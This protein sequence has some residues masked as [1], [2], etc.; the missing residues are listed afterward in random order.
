MITSS[1]RL[2]QISPIGAEVLDIDRTATA[3]AG[4]A[5]D[6]ND[7]WLKYGLLLF[8]NVEDAE[9][10]LELSRC[11]GELEIHPVP[12]ARDSENPYFIEIGGSHTPRPYIFDEQN[13][14]SGKLSWHRD[15]AYSPAIAKGAMLRMVEMPASM[16]ETLFADT[17]LAYDGLSDS[18]KRRLEGLEY[19]AVFRNS[20]IDG[21]KGATW[22]TARE[23]TAEEFPSGETGPR[24][25]PDPTKYPH[26]IHPA[27]ITHPESSRKCI[28]LSPTHAEHFLG[29]DRSESD[30]LMAE[31]VQHMTNEQYVYKHSWQR[32]DAIVWDNRRII[33][34]ASGNSPYESR[35]GLRTTLAD[36]LKVSRYLDPQTAPVDTP[37]FMD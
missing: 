2:Q 1:F 19:V 21:G 27:V 32:N 17:A 37:V 33:H 9:Q 36:T 11:F 26:V 6:L 34:S 14:L 8:R 23:P 13:L 4:K 35:R 18:M 15:T 16:G 31:L 30:D 5:I 7:A 22:S 20:S 28:Y 24:N 25:W 29:M 3:D 12:E 10:Q